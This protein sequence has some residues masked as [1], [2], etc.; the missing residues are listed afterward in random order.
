MKEFTCTFAGCSY[1]SHRNYDFQRHL[2][3]HDPDKSKYSCEKCDYK[4]EAKYLVKIHSLVHTHEKPFAC[5]FPNCTFRTKI[6][7]R[8]ARHKKLK[9]TNKGCNELEIYACE[10]CTYRTKLKWNLANHIKTHS[11]N[12]P[13]ACEVRGCNYRARL[14]W[15]LT[16]HTRRHHDPSQAFLFLCKFP[17]CTYKTTAKHLLEKHQK[18]HNPNRKPEFVC[19]LC[20]Q[21]YH[22]QDSLQ[23]HIAA[24]HTGEQCYNCTLCKFSSRQQIA[25]RRHTK[26]AHTSDQDREHE[27]TKIRQKYKCSLCSYSNPR[28]RAVINHEK[29][30]SAE[31]PFACDICSCKAKT[32]Y[33]L[34]AHVK[35]VHEVPKQK[36]FQ[37]EICNVKVLYIKQHMSRVHDDNT[38]SFPCPFCN[39][40]TRYKGNLK[41]HVKR[42]HESVNHDDQNSC[43]SSRSHLKGEILGSA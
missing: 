27:R 23:N 40:S 28:K 16:M 4:A 30:H 1:R 31:K 20:P 9:H 17:S 36:I 14:A 25:L 8:L 11:A 35:K 13:F 5:D 21:G 43:A 32:K 34:K 10:N 19:S 3:R 42:K 41:G 26:T 37:C 6:K 18:T 7:K 22:S 38:V 15:N 2:I 33:Y 24:K 39:Y 29:T 12:K